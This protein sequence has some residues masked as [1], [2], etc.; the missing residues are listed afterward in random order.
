MQPELVKLLLARRVE[1]PHLVDSVPDADLR[2]VV[3]EHSGHVVAGEGVG[4]EA[5]QEAGLTHP[6]ITHNNTLENVGHYK[7]LCDNLATRRTV[8]MFD[9]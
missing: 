1:Q 2:G 8:Y 6:A 9:D 7:T 5:D 4:G 3:L